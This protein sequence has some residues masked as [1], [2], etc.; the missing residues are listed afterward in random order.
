[1]DWRNAESLKSYLPS[2]FKK[3]AYEG[4]FRL[5]VHGQDLAIEFE[6]GTAGTFLFVWLGEGKAGE[7]L[8]I[9]Q[10]DLNVFSFEGY[11]KQSYYDAP[12]TRVKVTFTKKETTDT[13]TLFGYCLESSGQKIVNTEFK[14]LKEEYFVDNAMPIW[15]PQKFYSENGDTAYQFNVSEE[16]TS[17]TTGF[18]CFNIYKYGFDSLGKIVNDDLFYHGGMKEVSVYEEARKAVYQ[19]LEG[20]PSAPQYVE[21]AVDEGNGTAVLT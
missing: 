14:A 13:Y 6:D 8:E 12:E 18:V 3:E 17:Q 2:D 16:N 19:L 9:K 1:M 21:I 5:L 10:T 15:I 4:K 7:T 20:A 11:A